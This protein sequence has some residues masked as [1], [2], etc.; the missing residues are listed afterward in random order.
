MWRHVGRGRLEKE[1]LRPATKQ[2]GKESGSTAHLCVC[3]RQTTDAEA[4]MEKGRDKRGNDD[5]K[6]ETDH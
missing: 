1:H 5:R 3:N 2:Q 4:E 6:K